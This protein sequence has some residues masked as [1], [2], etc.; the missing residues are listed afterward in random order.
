[1]DV[2]CCG[3]MFE[4][5][6]SNYSDFSSSVPAD[7]CGIVEARLRLGGCYIEMSTFLKH[8]MF[9]V[10]DLSSAEPEESAP[11]TRPP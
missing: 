6:R 1:M 3:L 9:T 2:P 4:D 11:S 8:H 5:W 7:F 10:A